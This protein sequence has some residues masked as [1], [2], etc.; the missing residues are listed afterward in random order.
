VKWLKYL[1]YRRLLFTERQTHYLIF[2]ESNCET[3]SESASRRVPAVPA[4]R[5]QIIFQSWGEREKRKKAPTSW[6][7]YSKIWKRY[8][9]ARCRNWKVERRGDCVI[10]LTGCGDADE[11]YSVTSSH[12]SALVAAP[13]LLHVQ[14][15]HCSASC[16]GLSIGKRRRASARHLSYWEIG[17]SRSAPPNEMH[18]IEQWRRP[19]HIAVTQPFTIHGAMLS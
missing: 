2:R 19:L 7:R 1:V 14:C 6:R 10:A 18:L 13:R 5:I 15:N 9:I 17:L 8:T 16:I 12:E 3:Y 4:H 11:R